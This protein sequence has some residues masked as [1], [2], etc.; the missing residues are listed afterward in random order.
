MFHHEWNIFGWI[1]YTLSKT[2]LQFDSLNYGKEFFAK[3]DRRHD[4]SIVGT[5]KINS[6]TR[7]SFTWVYGTG[8]A[9]TLPISSI[10]TS[11]Y[12]FR[13]SYNYGNQQTIYGERNGFRMP[14]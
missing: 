1:G 11:N 4:L 6:K 8:N 10:Q 9:L 13:N 3:Y 14:T 7:L 2:I 12:P 5:Y